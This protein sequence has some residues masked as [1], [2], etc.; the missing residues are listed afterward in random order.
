MTGPCGH[1]IRASLR[2]GRVRVYCLEGCPISDLEYTQSA[3][4]RYLAPIG[5]PSLRAVEEAP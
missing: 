2:L 4:D 5:V 3:H 1:R